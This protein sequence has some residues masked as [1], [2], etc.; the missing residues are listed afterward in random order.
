MSI[1]M[2]ALGFYASRYLPKLLEDPKKFF[3][4]IF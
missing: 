3:R 4:D 1:W 2:T